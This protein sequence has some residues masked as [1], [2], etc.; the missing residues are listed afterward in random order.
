RGTAATARGTAEREEPDSETAQPNGAAAATATSGEPRDAE[1]LSEDD[2]L[3]R[4]RGRRGGRRRSRREEGGEPSFDDPRPAS[5][6]VEVAASPGPDEA[7]PAETGTASP[8]PNEAHPAETGAAVHAPTTGPVV[9]PWL[10]E[11]EGGADSARHAPIA[12]P[13]PAGGTS[14]SQTSEPASAPDEPEEPVTLPAAAVYE[15]VAA[16][17]ETGVEATPERPALEWTAE[18]TAETTETSHPAPETPPAAPAEPESEHRLA[19]TP[20]EPEPPEVAEPQLEP[21]QSVLTVTEKPPRPR[22]GWWQRL[23]QS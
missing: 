10:T 11:S 2:K 3:H 17:D 9:V 19:A 8:G 23:I 5:E 21:E 4:R 20:P 6:T 15:A 18:R 7:D 1:T 14:P 12:A 16:P 22:K 13:D